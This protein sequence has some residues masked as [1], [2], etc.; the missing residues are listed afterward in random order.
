MREP[1]RNAGG[2]EASARKKPVQANRRR[3]LGLEALAREKRLP[4]RKIKVT[5][6]MA[7]RRAQRDGRRRFTKPKRGHPPRTRVRQHRGTFSPIRTKLLKNWD[8]E[9]ERPLGV[10]PY[11]GKRDLH[12]A[13]HR[14]PSKRE[15]IRGALASSKTKLSILVL[16]VQPREGPQEK[17]GF[18]RRSQG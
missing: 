3:T 11:K 12:A 14:T 17:R 5:A 13:G 10:T 9:I 2:E 7:R 6:A 8:E 18:T 4:D 1:I 15:V 16:A